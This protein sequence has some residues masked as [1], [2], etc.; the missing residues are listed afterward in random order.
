MT[1]LRQLSQKDL[2][3]DVI[4]FHDLVEA[5]IPSVN[6]MK[7]MIVNVS[8]HHLETQVNCKVSILTEE[9]ENVK[10]GVQR[11]HFCNGVEV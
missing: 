10:L 1:N 7:P 8:H 9:K 5:I 4:F 2:H 6:F 3:K 11:I